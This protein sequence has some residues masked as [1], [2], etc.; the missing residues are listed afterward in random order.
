VTERAETTIG[1][2]PVG[3]AGWGLLVLGILLRRRLVALLGLA[4]VVADVTVAELGGFKAMNEGRQDAGEDR[5][6]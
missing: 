1:F 3:L 6:A 4:G 5:V 2:G